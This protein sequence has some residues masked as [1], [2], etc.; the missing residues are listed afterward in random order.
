MDLNLDKYKNIVFHKDKFINKKIKALL[1]YHEY[2]VL[3]ND[4]DMGEQIIFIDKWISSLEKEEMY[5]VIPSFEKRKNSLLKKISD[6]DKVR[7]I[8]CTFMG[9]ISKIKK[10][11]NI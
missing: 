6:K 7:S 5:E 2:L 3:K 8:K 11:F 4:L 1:L 9:V 10:M